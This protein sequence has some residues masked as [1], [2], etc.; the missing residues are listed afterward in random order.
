MSYSSPNRM[1]YTSDTFDFG[2]GA[3]GTIT[4]IGPKDKKGRLW[5]AGVLGP[6]EAFAGG[7]TTP[8]ISVGTVADPDAYM[9]EFPMGALA[10]K[11]P[12]SL[13]ST[14]L[15]S[16]AGFATYMLN[17]VLPANTVI[18]MTLVASTGS[19]LAGMAVAWITIDWDD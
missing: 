1:T 11:T 8:F 12:K 7:T 13:R 10:L 6:S 9:D 4:V 5:D 14:Y 16:E 2:G 15:P 17:E 18:Q 19:G 3:D